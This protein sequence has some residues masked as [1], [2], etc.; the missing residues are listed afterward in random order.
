MVIAI[1]T[2]TIPAFPTYFLSPFSSL[3][4]KRCAIGSEKPAHTPWQKP[5]M[6]KQMLPVEPTAAKAETLR[7]R[8]TIIVSIRL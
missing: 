4:P 8:P 6:R 7:K 1:I 3:A 2:D 5:M